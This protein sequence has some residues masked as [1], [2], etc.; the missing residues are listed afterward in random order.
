MQLVFK[1]LQEHE[2]PYIKFRCSTQMLKLLSLSE[3]V[4]HFCVNR[5]EQVSEVCFEVE[6]FALCFI[7]LIFPSSALPTP[8]SSLHTWS[9][10]CFMWLITIKWKCSATKIFKI[11]TLQS[12]RVLTV[13]V[14]LRSYCWTTAPSL[15][16]ALLCLLCR[17]GPI[18]LLH[19]ARISSLCIACV[20]F[21]FM[22]LRNRYFVLQVFCLFVFLYST[23]FHKSSNQE[24][25]HTWDTRWMQL[26]SR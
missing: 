6:V 1:Y 24:L 16:T 5:V 7:L 20:N 14:G 4:C 13:Q 26:T 12:C 15:W 9:E 2:Y 8:S 18:M 23:G 25:A 10:S 19:S 17:A 21:L 22:I 11:V 3:N